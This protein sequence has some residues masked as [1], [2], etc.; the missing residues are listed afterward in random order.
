MH[1]GT[2]RPVK[3]RVDTRTVK[4]SPHEL[5]EI[6]YDLH[7]E[8]CVHE[9]RD[10][11]EHDRS[12]AGVDSRTFEAQVRLHLPAMPR[13]LAETGKYVEMYDMIRPVVLVRSAGI[14]QELEQAELFANASLLHSKKYRARK[15]LTLDSDDGSNLELIF[16]SVLPSIGHIYQ[17]RLHYLRS[18]RGD[19]HL[20]YGLFLPGASFPLT[21][22]ALSVCDRPYMADSLARQFSC[23][24]QD[25]LVITRMYGLPGIPANL[26]SI[27]IKH[28]I[29]ALR[30][31]S[32]TARLLLTAYNPLL[33]FTGAALRASGFRTFTTAPV[34]YRY[35]EFGE[36]TTRRQ[37]KQAM[38]PG[39]DTPP[40]VLA[41]R[42]IDRVTQKEIINH[43]KLTT[44][45]SMHDYIART[46]ANGS[47]PKMPPEDW[48]RQLL[49]YRKV[50]QEAWSFRT[51]HPSYLGDRT[52]GPA[53][54]GQC[55]V[56]SVWLARE[57][58]RR[59]S[60]EATYCYGDLLFHNN[61]AKPVTHHCWIEIGEDSN[62]KRM[63]IDLTCDQAE[64]L[65]GPVLC[66]RYDDLIDHGLN[67]RSR[68][69]LTLDELPTDRVWHRFLALSD[70]VDSVH[71][72]AP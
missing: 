40:N 7:I 60:V 38:P 53:S 41:V 49:A 35:T 20:H 32:D 61:V 65:N 67:Y 23:R 51:V 11:I 68:V 3:H 17:S 15:N 14:R 48:L 10:R 54:R 56:S 72:F 26:M 6:L 36:F 12:V 44:H 69:R 2:R 66:A 30:H 63:V 8:R 57:L 5:A 25:C 58:R 64:S 18:A 47:L 29:R 19:T 31:S 45:T 55:G 33:G 22:V 13:S 59:F 37:A 62:S 16:Q 24:Q 28:V 71:A 43:V 46:S 50:L 1:L 42:G 34:S 70:A 4:A 21:Y 27:T 52:T 9:N 39:H